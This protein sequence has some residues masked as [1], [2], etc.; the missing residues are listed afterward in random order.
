[1]SAWN[2]LDAG[3]L[4]LSYVSSVIVALCVAS[5]RYAWAF[6]E[7]TDAS[8][9]ARIQLIPA[10]VTGFIG[11]ERADFQIGNAQDIAAFTPGLEIQSVPDRMSIRGVGRYSA[12]LGF[13]Q[14]V[15]VW[16]D[17]IYH[18]EAVA[19]STSALFIG[20]TEVRRGPQ[21][22]L[23]GKNAI[24]GAVLLTSYR[25]T[26]DYS[27]AAFIGHDSRNST[28]VVGKISGPIKSGL[29]FLVAGKYFYSSGSFRNISVHGSDL[30]QAN[31]LEAQAQL[32]WSISQNA[33][34]WFEV[35]ILYEHHVPAPNVLITPYLT[36]VLFLDGDLVP[37]ANFGSTVINPSVTDP[38]TVRRETPGP[39][40]VKKDIFVTSHFDWT[41]QGLALKYVAGWYKND[42]S[43]RSDYD[44]SD[45]ESYSYCGFLDIHNPMSLPQ[46]GTIGSQYWTDTWQNEE[47][48]SGELTATYDGPAIRWVTGVYYDVDHVDKTYSTSDPLQVQLSTPSAYYGGP[49]KEV[50]DPRASPNSF[51]F[52][53]NRYS[54][55]SYAVFGQVD[56]KL[57]PE[58]SLQVGARRSWYSKRGSEYFQSIYWNPNTLG[59][60]A[61]LNV[62]PDECSRTLQGAW[63]GWSGSTT[64]SWSPDDTQILYAS[65]SHGY[66]SGGFELGSFDSAA[67]ARP[68][69]LWAYELGYKTILWSNLQIEG[70]VYYYDHRDL[71]IP[72]FGYA[73]LLGAAAPTVLPQFTNVPAAQNYGVEVESV[74]QATEDLKLRLAFSYMN[75]R[76]S[77][78]MCVSDLSYPF[79]SE[80][81]CG[82]GMVNIL[83]NALPVSPE[84]SFTFSGKYIFHLRSSYLTTVG[85]YNWNGLR[86][87]SLFNSPVHRAPENRQLNASLK[88]Q[89]NE[90]SYFIR[91][92]G[93]NLTN[94]RIYSAYTAGAAPVAGGRVVGQIPVTVTVRPQA[95]FGV[96]FAYWF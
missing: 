17:G 88:W 91:V 50:S 12:A 82:S 29:K 65:V 13:D 51:Y 75:S 14:S 30:D 67:I 38:Y 64:L 52:T 2:L 42:R 45:R 18:A 93:N 84:S 49:S 26:D 47:F 34:W 46:C 92:F 59:L 56:Y 55:V 48:W 87:Y 33:S 76:F 43:G 57:S 77:T 27:G 69:R 53:H 85:S 68:E 73:P 90:S 60:T 23:L 28:V 71:Q 24:G 20:N 7:T 94:N 19:L 79:A 1:M 37:Q 5:D 11:L 25:P 81:G 16:L 35:G 96:Q 63:A 78:A 58:W 54:S 32:Q 15:G 9:E 3:R 86:Y 72:G 66:K 8:T 44:G 70:D 22:T 61:A 6:S 80:A 39:H 89:R 74:W 31:N 40:S 62:T 21:G 83:G 95:T 10:A 41:I 4:A 36:D